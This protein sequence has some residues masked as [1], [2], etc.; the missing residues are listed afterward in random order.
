[1]SLSDYKVLWSVFVP[2]R[3]S[4]PILGHWVTY[5]NQ[6]L[7]LCWIQSFCPLSLPR[8]G[9]PSGSRES[10][11]EPLSSCLPGSI[12]HLLI[13]YDVGLLAPRS[14]A[15]EVI[16]KGPDI[17]Q[18]ERWSGPE[19]RRLAEI[20]S[21]LSGRS[22][23][24]GP[25][26][27]PYH[28]NFSGLVSPA[29]AF[30]LSPSSRI[31]RL[32]RCLNLSSLGWRKDTALFSNGKPLRARAEGRGLALRFNRCLIISLLPTLSSLSSSALAATERDFSCWN[33]RTGHGFN[34]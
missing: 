6:I 25:G 15:K 16:G 3:V 26:H 12:S 5:H 19:A 22:P 28:L 29:S 13:S 24:G 33:S 7:E 1:M 11:R 34:F 23:A 2:T 21:C 10:V 9:R 18:P 20:P 31:V 30:C 17:E 4:S 8:S 14:G 27:C 32:C